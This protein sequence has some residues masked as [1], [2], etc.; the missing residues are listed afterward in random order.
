MKVFQLLQTV[1]WGHS[2]V[3]SRLPSC[4]RK[5]SRL[6]N[7]HK[8]NVALKSCFLFHFHVKHLA[9]LVT[10]LH[11]FSH[12]IPRQH[13]FSDKSSFRHIVLCSLEILSIASGTCCQFLFFRLTL[14]IFRLLE[15]IHIRMDITNYI[16]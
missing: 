8:D 11:W 9:L 2:L 4:F 15:V 16:F 6:L 5:G 13:I 10:V 3:I 1:K 12:C 7:I 14:Y